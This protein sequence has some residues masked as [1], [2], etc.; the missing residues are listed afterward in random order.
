MHL[1]LVYTLHAELPYAARL[2]GST[3]FVARI[4][5]GNFGIISD[6]VEFFRPGTGNIS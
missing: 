5:D 6:E 3:Q 2:C 1:G 4:Y